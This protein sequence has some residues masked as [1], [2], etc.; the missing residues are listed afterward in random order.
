[1]TYI[2]HIFQLM[3]FLVL[4]QE[5]PNNPGVQEFLTL[6]TISSVP[7]MVCHGSGASVE[8]S[9]E[10]AAENALKPL[11]TLGLDRGGTLRVLEEERTKG[12]KALQHAHFILGLSGAV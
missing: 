4:L 1:M 5:S 10:H 9:R 7:P 2:N 11:M 12:K 6:V 3:F 8:E